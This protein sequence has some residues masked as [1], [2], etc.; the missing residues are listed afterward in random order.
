MLL[1]W[2]CIWLQGSVLI[3]FCF[4]EPLFS[5][6]RASTPSLGNSAPVDVPSAILERSYSGDQSPCEVMSP[7]LSNGL[8]PMPP[9][10]SYHGSPG[11]AVSSPPP[12]D[13]YNVG[14]NLSTNSMELNSAENR[15]SQGSGS[16]H[17]TGNNT[18]PYRQS[19]G[20]SKSS[21]SHINT[22]DSVGSPLAPSWLTALSGQSQGLKRP[23]PAH[24]NTSQPPNKRQILEKISSDSPSSSNSNMS[25]LVGKLHAVR[26]GFK[27]SSVSFTER[28][29]AK[30]LA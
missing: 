24:S 22:G 20:S 12:T 15:N 25:P 14:L 18:S 6:F 13:A 1:I 8:P 19:P 10:M 17:L 2:L 23:P 9:L 30:T 7:T 29:K 28:K 3:N 5:Y 26:V 21:S 16:R 11:L 27:N 4:D